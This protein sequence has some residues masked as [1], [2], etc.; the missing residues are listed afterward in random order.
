[1]TESAYLS[2]TRVAYDTVAVDY[3]A[4]LRDELDAKPLDRALLATFAELVD[5]NGTVADIGCGP[6]RVTA[7]LAGLGL[8]AFGVDLSPAMIEVA[9]TS[10]PGLR[11]DIGSMT[12]LAVDEGTLAGIVAWYSIIHIPPADR[13]AVFA[14]FH[15]AFAPGA[16]LLMAFQ[17]GDER[18]RLEHAYGHDLALDVYR[19]PVEATVRQLTDAGFRVHSRHEREP[20]GFEKTRQAYL[21]VT[22]P[23]MDAD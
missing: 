5:A 12:E 19:V 4:F 20:E 1:M 6:G 3:A 18:V 2:P 14:R 8:D 22:K 9:R 17:I 16:S 21:L 10:Y 7:H 11:F 15:R 13:S 23:P